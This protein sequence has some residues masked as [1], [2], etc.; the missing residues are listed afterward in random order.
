MAVYGSVETLSSMA[1]ALGI[2]KARLKYEK[3]NVV[4]SETLTLTRIVKHILLHSMVFLI[5]L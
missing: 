1:L 2:R 4:P 5:I 3:V